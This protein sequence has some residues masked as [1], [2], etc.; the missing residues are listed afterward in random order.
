LGDADG[1]REHRRLAH[2]MRNRRVRKVRQPVP[3][4]AGAPGVGSAPGTL[5]PTENA[6]PLSGSLIVVTGLPRSGTSMLMQ[7]LAAGGL[8]ILSDE[9]RPA[10]E[11]NPRGYLEFEPVKNLLAGSTWLLEAR[12]RAVKIVLPLLTGLPAGLACRVILCER[13]LDE[14]LDS[15]D[16]MLRRSNQPTATPQRRKQLKNEYARAVARAKTMLSR[17]PATQLLVMEHGAA[18]YNSLAAAEKINQFLGAGLDIAKM[19]AAIDPALHRNRAG[20]Q[21][22]SPPGAAKRRGYGESEQTAILGRNRGRSGTRVQR[23]RAGTSP[24][25]SKD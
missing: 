16:T 2:S 9:L 6:P 17:R 11:D 1:A 7:M 5:L 13:D 23:A 24:G 14:V 4:T 19:A 20:R 15:Q 8:S 3:D 10:D 22:G 21:A 12:G 18:V 25:R